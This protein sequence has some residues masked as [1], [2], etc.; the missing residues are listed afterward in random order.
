M[1]LSYTVE[2]NLADQEDIEAVWHSVVEEIQ[3]RYNLLAELIE[4][5][6][7]HSDPKSPSYQ[8]TILQLT[9]LQ[10]QLLNTLS[11]LITETHSVSPTFSTG[12]TPNRLRQ[13]YSHTQI[14]Q[15]LKQQVDQEVTL[16]K[17]RHA[18]D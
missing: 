14:L 1:L 5:F 17:E 13:V 6:E 16:V 2:D 18:L 3:Q 9:H 8:P 15:Q 11:T 7:H 10:Q 12:V 4:W